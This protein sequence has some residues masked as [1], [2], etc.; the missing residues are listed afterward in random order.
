[1]KE[2]VWK[3]ISKE[4]KNLVKQM[5]TKDPN[6]RISARLALHHKWFEMAPENEINIDLMKES[7]R[8]L[9]SFNAI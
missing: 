1:M 2:D 5:L 6:E 7:L 3:N 8:N 4:A 9:L